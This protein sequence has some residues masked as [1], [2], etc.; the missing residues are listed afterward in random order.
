MQDVTATAPREPH[1][2]QIVYGKNGHTLVLRYDD[3]DEAAALDAIHHW[4]TEGF[5]DFGY[6]DAAQLS[7]IVGSYQAATVA[8]YREATQ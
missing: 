1:T 2:R 5:A 8:Q 6:W 4:A 7:L 3:G